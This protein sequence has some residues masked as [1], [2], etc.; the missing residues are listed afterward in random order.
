MAVGLGIC[1]AV[2]EIL[3]DVVKVKW[4]NDVMVKGKKICGILIENQLQGKQF[5]QA[6]V[7]VG[8]NVNQKEFEWPNATSLSLCAEVNFDKVDVLY[9]VLKKLENRYEQ[10]RSGI[11]QRLKNDYYDFLF[12]KD[13]RHEFQ[14]EE[15]IFFGIIQGV[16][17]VGRLQVMVDGKISSFNFKEITFLK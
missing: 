13:E 11:F 15:K 5:S 12:W 1:D 2:A 3:G 8:L 7:G 16:D 17:E 14:S 4:P 9:K 10:L 6:V